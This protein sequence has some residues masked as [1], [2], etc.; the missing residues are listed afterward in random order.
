[1]RPT[2][3]VCMN[4]RL[5]FGAYQA[6]ADAG[7]SVPQDISVVSFDDDPIAAWLRPGLSTVA[8]PHE[9]MG[10]RAVD[11]LLGGQGTGTTLVPMSL[12][13]RRSVGPPA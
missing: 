5:A 4:D 12:R 6:L 1:V 9:T 10:R 11:L 7:L 3:V 13:R 2:A 8:L